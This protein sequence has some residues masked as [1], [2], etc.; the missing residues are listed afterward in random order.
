MSRFL[1]VESCGQCTPCKQD[2][3]A[4]ADLFDRVRR[5]E[6]DARDLDAID[7]RVSTVAD[8]ARC[9]L[10]SQ[11]QRVASSILHLFRPQLEAHVR[12]ERPA[13]DEE[14]I[15]AIV[16]LEGDTFVLDETQREKQPDW[17]FDAEDSGKSPA[18]R[19]DQRSAN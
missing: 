5:S 8:E 17:T 16:D 1:S 12:G 15:A 10:A 7:D 11:H 4:L 14:P 3:L 9:F 6:A 18:D 19:I 2:G 13:V